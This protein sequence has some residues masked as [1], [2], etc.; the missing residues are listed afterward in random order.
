M[1]NCCLHIA[2]CLASQNCLYALLYTC[3]K[4]MCTD[5]ETWTLLGHSQLHVQAHGPFIYM[6]W[7]GTLPTMQRKGFGGQVMKAVCAL[8][9]HSTSIA[10]TGNTLSSQ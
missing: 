2:I 7:F 5:G 10:P 9:S 6:A 4:C 8:P 3:V 1:R